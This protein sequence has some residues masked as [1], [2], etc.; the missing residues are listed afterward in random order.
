MP[1]WPLI[2]TLAAQTLATMAL[3]SLPAIAPAVAAALHV[4]G[5]LVG[6]FVSVVYGVGIISALFSPGFIHRYGA[7]PHAAR[8]AGGNRGDAAARRRRQRRVARHLRGGPGAGLRRR[9]TRVHASAGA[10]HAAARVQHG[11]VAAPDRRPAGRRARLAPAP[12][13]GRSTS[14]GARHCWRNFPP[15]CCSPR[16]L[17]SRAEAWDTDAS[18][19]RRL[20][21]RALLAP[22]AL[23]RD[24]PMLR[25]SVASFFY[26]G[27]QL[28]FIAFMTTHLTTRRRL[29]PDHRR[30]GARALPD[31]RRGHPPDLGLDR[32]SLADAG[33][34]AGGARVR[35]G[36]G[37]RRGRR[38][39]TGVEPCRR[40]DGRRHRRCTAGGYTGVAYAEYAHL[41]GAR[42]TEATG[43]GTAVMFAGVLLIPSSFG[44]TVAAS[45]GYALAYCHTGGACL[46]QRGSALSRPME[47]PRRTR[48]TETD[49]A[50]WAGYAGRIRPLPGRTPMAPAA[51][52]PSTAP[53]S[54]P[55]PPATPRPSRA[56]LA[57]LAVGTQPGGLDTASWQRLRTGK[58][59]AVRT[60]DLHGYTAQRA[61][62]RAG[63]LPPHRPGRGPPL[64]RG[65]HRPG[66][67][68]PPRAPALAEPPRVPHPGPG[69]R[70]PPR[71]QPRRR[72]PAAPPPAMTHAPPRPPH[73]HGRACRDHPRLRHRA[74]TR[75]RPPHPHP[76]HASRTTAEAA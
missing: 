10:A 59:P 64:R 47:Q 37:S 38:V 6:V 1:L 69:R 51:A 5:E 43:L 29:R 49:R 70:A 20:L 50:L 36:G 21:G 28:C 23:L 67:R 56:P 27:T 46:D 44:V 3:F 66:R 7:R 18:P 60:L 75:A 9:R 48:L 32:R 40:T 62:P 63:R 73:R 74:G 14:A 34:H 41:G 45:G 39:R 11:D 12:P 22:F 13:A 2:A 42:R 16:C 52:T 53:A 35:H 17:R 57:P 4:R 61:Y 55:R 58:L 25:L 54:A 24:G 33:P 72:P 71:R 15:S 19:T 26:S 8:R 30:P 76:T 31:H 65:R 68:A